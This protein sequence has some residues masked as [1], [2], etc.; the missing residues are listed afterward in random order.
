VNETAMKRLGITDPEKIIGQRMYLWG[1]TPEIIGVIKDYHQESLKQ[2][3]NPL[4]LVYDTEVKD[5]YSIKIKTGSSLKKTINLAEAK[6]KEAF[7]G[8]PFDYFFLDEHY[9]AQY[10]SDQRFEKVIGL[11]ALLAVC[12]ACLGLFGLSAYLVSQRTTEIGIRKV[13]GASVRQIMILV[14]KEFILT[15]FVANM[16]AWPIAYIL[17]KDWLNGFAYR[18]DMG[19]LSFVIP[20]A[21]IL[22]IAVLTV[23]TQSVRAANTDPVK[24]LRS[25]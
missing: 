4:V 8:N 15:V 2:S 12:I 16:V 13:L 7:P 11:F 17:L 25:E 6:Y 1:D 24:N 10:A 3:V 9:N 14:S 18:I 5:F 19:L 23:A 21:C 20:G 22:L